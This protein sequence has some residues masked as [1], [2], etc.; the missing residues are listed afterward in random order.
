MIDPKT[1]LT[2][3]FTL[4]EMVRSKSHPEVYNV[5]PIEYI[6]HLV[7]LCQWLEVLRQEYIERYNGGRDCP[8][9]INSGYRSP[10][11]NRA[12]GGGKDSNH[13]KGYAAD[14]RCEDGVQ[15]IRYA[16]L[17]I[18]MFRKADKLWDEIIIEKKGLRFWLHF[19]VRPEKGKDK[20]R[21][22]ISVMYVTL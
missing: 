15:A 11:L 21:G 18:E 3:H 4:G 14:I 1:K 5:P 13:L 17:L 10:M 2:P 22:R 20:N 8:V 19:A 12:V 16:C 6:D 7:N 9:V